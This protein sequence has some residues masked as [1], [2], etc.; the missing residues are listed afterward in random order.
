MQKGRP[1][2]CLLGYPQA[3]VGPLTLCCTLTNVISGS[4]KASG[5]KRELHLTAHETSASE[6]EKTA[7]ESPTWNLSNYSS[8]PCSNVCPCK[9]E[10][11]YFS[12]QWRGWEDGQTRYLDPSKIKIFS[13]TKLRPS[14]AEY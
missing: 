13:S 8:V 11:H 10:N 9:C 3:T 7:H 4:R 14:Y 5:C 1:W 12:R 6:A 2:G